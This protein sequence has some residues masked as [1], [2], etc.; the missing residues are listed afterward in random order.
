MKFGAE[1]PR[2]LPTVSAFNIPHS[3]SFSPGHQVV[4]K[5][6]QAILIS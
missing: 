2:S 6:Y 5:N 4:A 1:I 3:I